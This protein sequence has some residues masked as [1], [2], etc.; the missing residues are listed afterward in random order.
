MEEKEG[1]RNLVSS[2][3]PSTPLL[4]FHSRGYEKMSLW[5]IGDEKHQLVKT[6]PPEL[7]GKEILAYSHGWFIL[8]HKVIRTLMFLPLESSDLGIDMLTWSP[9]EIHTRNQLLHI[10]FASR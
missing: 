6:T 8:L 3:P 9:F 7:H 5:S 2:P 1:C 4:F 10:V